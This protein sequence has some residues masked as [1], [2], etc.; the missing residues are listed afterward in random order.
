VAIWSPDQTM[1]LPLPTLRLGFKTRKPS[2]FR[3]DADKRD[4]V[5]IGTATGVAV[6][7]GAPIGGMLFTVEEAGPYTSLLS[8]DS[9]L[10][11][12]SI[13]SLLYRHSILPPLS[14]R[15]SLLSLLSARSPRSPLYILSVLSVL[16]LLACRPSI[17]SPLLAPRSSLLSPPSSR[18]SLLTSL[19]Y[20]LSSIL[21]PLSSF[22]PPIPSLISSLS[23][24]P[25]PLS[26]LMKETRVWP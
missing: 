22:L 18:M 15:S 16:F 2:H 11:I 25:S 14:S 4:F 12:L 24:R 17:L 9:L 21:Y 6:A 3:N 7:F 1:C 8:L 10:R 20:P 26:P 23:S 5:A 13:F 19:L